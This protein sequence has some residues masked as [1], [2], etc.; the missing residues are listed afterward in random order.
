MAKS[1]I[2]IPFDRDF[3]DDIVR[4]SDGKLDP[5]HLA[6]EQ[7]AS[8]IERNLYGM[9]YD[10]FGDRLPEFVRIHFP[11]E[12]ERVEAEYQKA[13][14]ADRASRISSPARDR[15][16]APLVWKQVTVLSGTEARMRYKG[17]YHFAHVKN[18]KIK[19]DDGR[20]SPSEWASKVANETSRN[21]W[22]DLEFN[23]DGSWTRADKLR[24]KMHEIL[25]SN[26][27]GIEIEV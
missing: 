22:R 25:F 6:E 17:A 21:A 27:D 5:A 13:C 7:V 15:R 16:D 19:D 23:L 11:N 4:L 26:L 20:F 12:A 1:Y 2:Y 18:G 24:F 3:Y 9:A 14:S 10:W 8:L